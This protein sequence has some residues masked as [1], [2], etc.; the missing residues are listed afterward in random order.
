VAIAALAGLR[1]PNGAGWVHETAPQ[2]GRPDPTA[3]PIAAGSAVPGAARLERMAAVARGLGARGRHARAER[4]LSRCARALASRGAVRA[5]A[6]AACDLGDLLLDR[7][8][9]LRALDAYDQARTW[10]HDPSL[11]LR[12]LIGSGRALLDEG[13]LG[14]AEAAFR[15]AASAEGERAGKLASVWLGR[16]LWHRGQLDDAR[17]AVGGGHP[18]LQSRILL[19]MGQLEAAAHAARDAVA[20][21]ESD[22]ALACE[23]HLA[24][25][26][27]HAA[28]GDADAVRRDT[29][30]ASR[31]ARQTKNP[32]LRLTTAADAVACL[33]RCGIAASPATTR[34]LLRAANRLPPRAAALIR[35]ALRHPTSTDALVVPPSRA[36]TDLIEHFQMLIDALHDTADETSALQVI[37]VELQRSLRACSVVLRSRSLNQIVGAAGRSWPSEEPLARAVLNGGAALTRAGVTPE[38]VEPVRAAGAV[39][40]TIALRWVAG[41]NPSWVRVG[42]VLRCTAVAAAPLLRALRPIAAAAD[43]FPDDLLGPSRSA[44][45]VRDAIRRAA[46]APYPVLVEGESGSGKELVARAIHARGLRRARRFSAVNCAALTDDL[47][48]AELFGHARGAFTGA[49]SERAGL[50][51]EADQ[52]TLF[53]DEVGEL[54]ARAQAKLLRAVQEGEVR[55]LGENVPRR[56]DVRIVAATNRSLEREVQSGAFRA[57]LRFRLDVIRITIPPLR[58][59]AEDLSWLVERT[60]R[61]ASA[62]VGSRAVLGDD[63]IGA[64]L[65][66]DWPGNVREL[67]NVIASL[68]VHGPRRGRVTAALLPSRI[69]HES[70]R[71]IPRF[72]QARSEFERAFVRAALARAGGRR[73]AAAAQ[74]GVSRQ[75]LVKIIRRLGIK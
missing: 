44:E 69:A 49:I 73:S 36:E 64:L 31:A 56:V 59:R 66:Y 38:A 12:A 50:F 6:E 70:A 16:V 47:L 40:G 71:A 25:A 55:R 20:A 62:R 22:A 60:W 9:P 13:R 26:Y 68:A 8:R 52:G 29:E 75:G 21:S 57:D 15:T 63:L 5:A 17:I 27:V 2:Y 18:A 61:D 51:E 19:S 43:V 4:L 30:G 48:E 41:A 7:G 1:G 3:D 28:M 54:S 45:Q 23:A 42:D 11:A 33:G 34:R 35:T 14:D 37:A 58:E 24:A 74:L 32:V 53:L 46:A 10:T 65:R 72:D 67:Q 39:V